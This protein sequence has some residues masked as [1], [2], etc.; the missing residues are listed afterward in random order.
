MQ[1][2]R[3]RYLSLMGIDLY[4]ARQPEET[5]ADVVLEETS[6]Q[7]VIKE[8][9]TTQDAPAVPATQSSTDVTSDIPKQE[10]A[11]Q[12]AVQEVE[13]TS[14]EPAIEEPSE[15][16]A[17]QTAKADES[18]ASDSDTKEV[19]NKAKDVVSCHGLR[20]ITKSP[21]NG[22]LVVLPSVSKELNPE[23]RQLMS[24]MLNAINCAPSATGFAE[25]GTETEIDVLPMT[26]VKV[27]LVM[28]YATGKSLIDLNDAERVPGEEYCKMQN[29]PLVV[30]IHP[31]ELVTT[32][33]LKASAWRDLKLVAKLLDS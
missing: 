13:P 15:L 16:E 14:T 25:A 19:I 17:V 2:K 5:P 32:P 12:S 23:A 26:A 3:E 33:E 11:E 24:K 20:F 6:A 28:D 10:S 29:L 31:Q 22:L 9:T 1:N 4:Q 7:E 18:A 21:A 8:E 27:V 30:S